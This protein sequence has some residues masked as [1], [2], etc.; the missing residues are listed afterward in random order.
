MLFCLIIA[1]S[2]TNNCINNC[3]KPGTHFKTG[4]ECNLILMTDMS[5]TRVQRVQAVQSRCLKSAA[6]DENSQ[7]MCQLVVCPQH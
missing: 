1:T 5:K 4:Y 2:L 7:R 3:I 6:V